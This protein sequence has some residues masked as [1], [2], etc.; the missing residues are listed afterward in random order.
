MSFGTSDILLDN[1]CG[2]IMY[3]FR[4][5]YVG[6]IESYEQLLFA[7]SLGTADKREYGG[8]WNQLLC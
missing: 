3:I 5:K 4:E 1:N 2:R 7:F 6:R 8:R